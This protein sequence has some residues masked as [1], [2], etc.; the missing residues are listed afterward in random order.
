MSKIKKSHSGKSAI[1]YIVIAV[2]CMAVLFSFGVGV[3]FRILYI[4]VEGA[5][6]HSPEDIISA[7]EL[8]I[9]SG[10][11]SFNVQDTQLKVRED[12]PLIHEVTISRVLPN[13]IL[14][15]IYESIPF[16]TIEHNDGT[17]II[18]SSGRI[19]EIARAASSG[20]I[21]IRGFEAIAPQEGSVLR[22]DAGEQSRLTHLIDI[23]SAMQSAGIYDRV[24]FLDVTSIARVFFDFDEI[25]ID[26]GAPDNVMHKLSRLESALNDMR[27]PGERGRFDMSHSVT[28]HWLPE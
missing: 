2:L 6:V 7:S 27:A 13:R 4:D 11:F 25:R 3:F 18:D 16:A 28:W 8:E 23:M 20:L 12:K 24:T 21:E 15:E 10:M 5:I 17:L 1:V 26:L 14:I 19:L 9:G 22:T